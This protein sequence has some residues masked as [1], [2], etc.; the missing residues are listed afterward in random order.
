MIADLG[1][2]P[3]H[4]RLDDLVISALLGIG[5]FRGNTQCFVLNIEPKRA[6]LQQGPTFQNDIIA[7]ALSGAD[8]D[9]NSIVRRAQVVAGLRRCTGYPHKRWCYQ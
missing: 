8:P 1:E 5:D 3:A 7:Q 6:I 9:F 4:H 2:F